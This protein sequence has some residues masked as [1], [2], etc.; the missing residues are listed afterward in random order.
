[1]DDKN[2]YS[3]TMVEQVGYELNSSRDPS[4][5]DRIVRSPATVILRTYK[6]EVDQKDLVTS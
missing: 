3:L 6:K 2:G 4:P 1:M 5:T